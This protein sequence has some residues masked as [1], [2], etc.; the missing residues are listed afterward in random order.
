MSNTC[1]SFGITQLNKYLVDVPC[2]ELDW[3]AESPKAPFTV[4][5]HLSNFIPPLPELSEVKI[6]TK[7]IIQISPFLDPKDI[8]NYKQKQN[9]F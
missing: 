7:G 8:L 1:Y 6:R 3:N 4:S 2:I 5:S 9:V